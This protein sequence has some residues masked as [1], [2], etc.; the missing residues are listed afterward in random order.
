M[1]SPG[2]T[3]TIESAR[4]GQE[5]VNLKDFL[6]QLSAFR[7]VSFQYGIPYIKKKSCA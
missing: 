5:H 7:R 1:G 2:L 6:F 3:L 4:T